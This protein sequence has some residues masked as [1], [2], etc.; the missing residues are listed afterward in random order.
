MV[1]IV[2]RIY[3]LVKAGLRPPH[4][5]ASALTRAWLPASLLT[6]SIN[7][8]E[9]ANFERHPL[10]FQTRLKRCHK[11]SDAKVDSELLAYLALRSYL[12]CPVPS[13]TVGPRGKGMPSE[14]DT[15]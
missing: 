2:V 10:V 8:Q 14:K 4:A 6:I 7:E 3:A 9:R 1:A 15:M 12:L 11:K 5:A 13:G